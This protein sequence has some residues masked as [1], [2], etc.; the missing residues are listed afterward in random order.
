M[1]KNDPCIAACRF[2]GRTGWCVGCGRTIPE[3]RAWTKLTPFRR[4]ALLR[5]LPA[6]VRKVQDAPRED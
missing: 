6:R 2:D 4:T 1:R 5:D 3:I